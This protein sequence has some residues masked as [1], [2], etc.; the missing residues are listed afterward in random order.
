[1]SP[2]TYTDFMGYCDPTWVSDYNYA[3]IATRAKAVNT[4]AFIFAGEQLT[5]WHG[6]LLR[7]DGSA[8]FSGMI[9][10]ELPGEPSAARALDA[11]GRVVSEIEVV[12]V[13]LSDGGDSILYVPEPS[14]QW[15]AI[16][17][18]DRVLK[19]AEIAAAPR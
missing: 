1:M 18:G 10:D 19:L 17:L 8:G 7:A 14:A 3:K 12:R 13:A 16:D 4:S 6:V 11:Q 5:R 9:S 2:A 15:A